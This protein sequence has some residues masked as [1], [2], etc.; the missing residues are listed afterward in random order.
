MIS[1]VCTFSN[2][3]DPSEL[4]WAEGINQALVFP[5]RH[6]DSAKMSAITTFDFA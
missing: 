1:F 6:Y 4:T 2:V 5:L 3:L